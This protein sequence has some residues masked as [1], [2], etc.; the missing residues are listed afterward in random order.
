MACFW[1]RHTTEDR[2]TLEKIVKAVFPLTLSL[3]TGRN[4]VVDSG[5]LNFPR[6]LSKEPLPPDLL[7]AKLAGLW[8]RIVANIVLAAELPAPTGKE[9]RLGE[10]LTDRMVESEL[11]NV[12]RDQAGNVAGIFPGRE[13]DRDILVT[14]HLDKIWSDSQDHTV[15]VGVDR[16]SGRGIADNSLGVAILASLPLVLKELGIQLSSNLILLGATRSLGRGDLAGMRFFAVNSSRPIAG[17]LCLEGVQLGRLSSS[18][19]GMARC[20]LT[21]ELLHPSDETGRHE[22]VEKHHSFLAFLLE[23]RSKYGDKADILIGSLE[24]G[25]G[26]N[27]PPSEITTRFEVRSQNA[28]EVQR[29]VL[30]L[31]AFA[32]QLSGDASVRAKLEVLATRQ[33]GGLD[34]SDPLRQIVCD[35]HDELGIRTVESPS[36]SELSVLLDHEISA[37]TLGLT[38]G[39]KLHSRQEFIS[40]SPLMDGLIQLIIILVRVDENLLSKRRSEEHGA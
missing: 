29:L 30:E 31:R 9:L 27:V 37:V 10:F 23:L 2:I 1:G 19:L 34:E 40:L 15:E 11:L 20:E 24:G 6:S 4:H 7:R 38:K 39:G 17:A 33:P 8:S 13:G 22:V 26:Y 25:E 14:A 18:S 12:S 16:L 36:I 21:V 35:V 32:E 28:L 5:N 3:A